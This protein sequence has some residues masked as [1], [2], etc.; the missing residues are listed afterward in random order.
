MNLKKLI[1]V[2]AIAFAPLAQANIL[3]INLD[4]VYSYAPVGSASNVVMNYQLGAN[5][6]VTGFGWDFVLTAYDPSW[7]S[8]MRV[9]LTG[10]G[11]IILNASGIEE[12]GTEAHASDGLYD[13]V[14]FG[15]D[16]DIGTDG[17]LRV[18][19]FDT[20]DDIQVS[21]DGVWNGTL[22]VEY[23]SVP[24]PASLALLGLGLAGLGAMRRRKQ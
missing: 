10:I 13:L 3:T 11:G 24:D 2:S 23:S 4:D 18:E 20:Y 9:M 5:A 6:H 14:Q 8:E 21:P 16:F 12:S 15:L 1:A 17:L 7:L 19:F 22:T